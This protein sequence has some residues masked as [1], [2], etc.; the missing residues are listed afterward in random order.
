MVMSNLLDSVATQQPLME[1]FINHLSTIYRLIFIQYKLSST[2]IFHRVSKNVRIV[3]KIEVLL[4]VLYF[5]F[6]G[7][8]C[9]GYN[10]SAQKLIQ[11]SPS[12][13]IMLLTELKI[14]PKFLLH[15]KSVTLKYTYYSVLAFGVVCQAL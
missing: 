6:T 13:N 5:V 9:T 15:R 7:C 10:F 12:C 2:S 11:V 1:M 4:N 14:D 8:K 3:S